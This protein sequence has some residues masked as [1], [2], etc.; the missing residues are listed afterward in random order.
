MKFALFV[1]FAVFLVSFSSAAPA[2][3]EVAVPPAVADAKGAAGAKLQQAEPVQ[4][5]QKVSAQTASKEK[6]DEASH[7]SADSKSVGA[8]SDTASTV[9][10][11]PEA[12]GSMSQTA[13][14]LFS[15]MLM[16]LIAFFTI[17]L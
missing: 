12:N 15:S 5:D 8:G 1:V 13:F 2:A 17:K 9:A 11:H 4:S 6:P 7:A 14:P 10:P 16:L 3:E